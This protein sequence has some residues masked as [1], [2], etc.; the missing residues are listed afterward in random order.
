VSADPDVLVVGAGAAGIAAARRLRALG[1]RVAV[2]EAGPRVGGRAHTDHSLGAPLDLGASW[3]HEAE[4]N[5]LTPMAQRL[6]L[7]LHDT[8]RR[9]R[10]LLL[11]AEG[12][13]ATQAE[14]AAWEAAVEAFE[15]AAEARAA[16]GGPDIPLSE[17][18]PRGGPWDATAAH[19]L[20]E[21]INASAADRTSLRDYVAT[22]LGGWNPQVREGLGTLVARLAE[23]L[24]VT[25]GAPVRR[26]RWGGRGGAVEAEG[27]RGPMRARA[28]IVTVS[29]AVFAAG[30]IA[31][32]P[33]LPGEVREAIAGLPLGLLSKVAL[34]AAPGAPDR[35]G[36]RDFARLGRQVEGPGDGPMS[37]ML[38]PFGRDHAVGFI[39][40]DRAWALSREGPAAA[41][42]EARAELAR[43]FGAAAVARA[44]PPGPGAAAASSWGED[45]LFLGAYSHAVPGQAGARAVLAGA[46]LADGRLRFAGEACHRRYAATVG[47]AWSSG[48]DAADAVHAALRVSGGG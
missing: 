7:G 38:W 40:S 46:A 45:P 13:P 44:F 19:W 6:G 8:G 27:P 35:L 33:P 37:W 12:R 15:A 36:M 11:T 47:G 16:A 4:H 39:G 10:D 29:T 43:Y 1:R 17:A 18:V 48:E 30:G 32:D 22:G 21:M 14:R 25:L 2:L 24:P 31:F 9:R 42:A 3:L 20:A 5:P 23:D 34:R 41:E 28:A 26:L